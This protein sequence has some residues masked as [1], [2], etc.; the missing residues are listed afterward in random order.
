MPAKSQ[1]QQ[2]FFGVVKGIQQGTGKGTGK[3]KKAAKDMSKKDVDDFAS[4][5]HKG[6]PYKVAKESKVRSLIRKMV[7]EIMS[8]DF[9][10]A[11][12]KEDRKKFDKMRQKQSEVLGYKLTGKP[13]VKVEIGDATIKEAKK[14]DYK[15][16]YK[17]FQ[18]STKSKKYR[19]ELNKYNRQKGTYG[20]GDKKD[21]SHKG[22]KIAGFEEQSKNRG[23]R[24]KSRLKKEG[25]LTE[26]KAHVIYVLTKELEKA[27]KILKQK[28][29]WEDGKDYDIKPNRGTKKTV[30]IHFTK[31]DKY[32]VHNL[33]SNKRVAT[34]EG[35]LTEG[36]SF[37]NK[38][39]KSKV[40]DGY[41][42]WE[43]IG[44]TDKNGRYKVRIHRHYIH[45]P[46]TGYAN[47]R[48]NTSDFVYL[49][50]S[51]EKDNNGTPYWNNYT[52]KSIINNYTNKNKI[53]T[54]FDV[55]K[56]KYG[57]QAQAT[58]KGKLLKTSRNLVNRG[59]GMNVE[60]KLNEK[61]V[62]LSTMK[63]ASFEP[64]QWVQILGKKGRVKLDKKDV[65]FLAKWIRQNS[66][67]HG[68]GWSFTEGKLN[69]SK[70]LTLPNGVKVTIDFN[71]IKFKGS[72]GAPVFLD[73]GE[74]LKFFR[75]TT[76]YLRYT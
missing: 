57:S 33:L 32:A 64:G 44:E 66:G 49:T 8:E 45:K 48:Q 19:A 68:M 55:I 56:D 14:R 53:Q 16:E 9:A 42:N 76:K 11:L 54:A 1:A 67:K 70:T 10:G 38:K 74:L 62:R 7:R 71:G 47:I 50:F 15:A 21:A 39:F 20:N 30:G 73:R 2:R 26:R 75:A 59:W 25:K 37:H 35:K 23:R 4:T 65:K 40:E 29:R 72:K 22:G 41:I 61:T 13:D 46:K 58:S 60:G 3:A 43:V 28:F 12:K 52:V 63:D 51:N 5:K 69:E 27:K 6:L 18:S 31:K 34:Y 24:E 17:K 36:K